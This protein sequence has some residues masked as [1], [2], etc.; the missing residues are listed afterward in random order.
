VLKDLT[1]KKLYEMRLQQKEKL[2]AMGELASGV[3]HEIRNPLNAI[4]IIAQRFA[5]DFKTTSNQIEF[6][7]LATTVITATRQVSHIIQRFLD[8]ARPAEINLKICQ[9][10]KIVNKAVML[11]ESQ[12]F[13]KDISLNYKSEEIID[14]ILDEDQIQ[15]VLVNI[16]QN[17]I[18]ATLAGGWIDIN[19]SRHDGE[20][21]V[22]ISDNGSGISEEN[23]KKIFDLYFTTKDNGSG[24]GLSISHRIISQHDGRIEVDSQVD[25][26]TTFNVILPINKSRV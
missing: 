2:T 12:A 13:E 18:Q 11:I 4:S 23:F 3:A 26:G 20:A 10:N 19:L 7:E 22:K 24:M 14:L 8:F 9:L 6:K 15:Q 17:A 5:H 21:I 16:L 1:D 25:G